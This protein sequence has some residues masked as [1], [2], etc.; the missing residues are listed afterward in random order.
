MFKYIALS[1]LLLS[2]SLSH[3]QE[4]AD[5][6]TMLFLGD[7]MQHTAQL[8]S[9]YN[10]S[11]ERRD[12]DSYSYSCYFKYLS[13]HFNRADIV[14][15]NMETTFGPAPYSGYPVFCSPATLAVDAVKSGINLLFAANNHSADKRSAGLEGSIGLYR[16]LRQE[17]PGTNY[18]GIYSDSTDEEQMHPLIVKKK[19]FSIA[20]LNYTYGTN[21]IPVSQPY[22]VKMLDSAI[23]KRDMER[24]RMLNPDFTIISVHWGDEYKLTPSIFQKRWER[25]FYRLGAD[26]IIGAHPHVP[27]D[28]VSY[29]DSEGSIKNITAY[30]LG[31]AISNMTAQ[32]TRIGI[33]LEISITKDSLNFKKIEPPVNHYIWTSRP[34]ATGGFFTII[35]VKDYLKNPAN[36][37]IKGE[38]ELIK[39]YYRSFSRE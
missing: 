12:P 23:I 8:E 18:T 10:G 3:A 11:G 30:S 22:I 26:I 35:P 24:A 33:M 15:A 31:N 38:D 2:P 16:R 19:G 17:Y 6:L 20:F 27:Q 14:A 4:R 9:A 5:T 32:N 13:P 29:Y 39:R 28:V 7:I 21:G 37:N 36:Y 34:A 1:I 25:L